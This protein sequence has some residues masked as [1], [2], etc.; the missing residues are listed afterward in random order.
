MG[1]ASVFWSPAAASARG[2][3]GCSLLLLPVLTTGLLKELLADSLGRSCLK[4]AM[5]SIG[6][7]SSDGIESLLR[8]HARRYGLLPMHVFMTMA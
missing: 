5:S 7:R 2:S 1:N 6:A 3:C 8:Y 4:S